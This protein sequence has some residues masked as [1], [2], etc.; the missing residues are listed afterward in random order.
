M[1]LEESNE[2]TVSPLEKLKQIA[3]RKKREG[4]DAIVRAKE[5]KLQN[6][7]SAI[8]NE[9]EYNITHTRKYNSSTTRIQELEQELKAPL[10]ERKTIK[11]EGKK[12]VL[13]LKSMEE[14]AEVLAGGKSNEL[15]QEVFGGAIEALRAIKNNENFKNNLREFANLKREIDAERKAHAD[16]KSARLTEF[17]KKYPEIDSIHQKL[18]NIQQRQNYFKKEKDE[19]EFMMSSKEYNEYGPFLDDEIAYVPNQYGQM[20][21]LDVTLKNE[22][23]ALDTKLDLLRKEMHERQKKIGMQE[24]KGKSFFEKEEKFKSKMEKLWKD[25]K[26]EEQGRESEI[27]HSPRGL[28]KLRERQEKIEKKVESYLYAG[29]NTSEKRVEVVKRVTTIREFLSLCQQKLGQEINDASLSEEEQL[30][31]DLNTELYH[32]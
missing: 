7:K 18:G 10:D 23:E 24:R 31:V 5:D 14:G 1:T 6:L 26:K 2:K 30:I 17:K 27:F 15:N 20:K 8:E 11:D 25:I 22:L 29:F 4:V 16:Q 12:A 19:I 28:Q 21:L 32:S 13:E 9:T 3:A